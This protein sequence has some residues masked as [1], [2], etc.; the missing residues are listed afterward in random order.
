MPQVWGQLLNQEQILFGLTVFPV[1][2]DM[3]LTQ[4]SPLSIT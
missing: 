1:F 3:S 2:P 4:N